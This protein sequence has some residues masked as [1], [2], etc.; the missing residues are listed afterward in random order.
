MTDVQILSILYV[1]EEIQWDFD[2]A[3]AISVFLLAVQMQT[4][5]RPLQVDNSWGNSTVSS[6][7]QQVL[8]TVGLERASCLQGI[9]GFTHCISSLCMWRQRCFVLFS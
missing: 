1:T 4:E 9:L 8:R 7:S 5:K 6:S 2:D 3:Y